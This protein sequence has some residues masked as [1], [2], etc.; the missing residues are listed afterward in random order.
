MGGVGAVASSD[1]RALSRRVDLAIP[2]AL[3]VAAGV[4]WWWSAR[5]ADDMTSMGSGGMG[6]S[7]SMSDSMSMSSYVVGW[8]AMMA[9]MMFP[10][11]APMVKLYARASARG[12]VAPVPFFVAGYLV[13][14]SA[15][16]VPAFFV[17]RA[18]ADPLAEGALWT[19]R[20]AGATFVAAALYQFTPLKSVCLR[21]CRSP[22]SFFLH[23]GSG[24]T[25]TAPRALRLGAAHGGFCLGCCWAIMAVLVAV[26]TMHLGWMLALT[27]VIFA[28]KVAPWGEKLALVAAAG[29]AVF[30]VGLLLDPSAVTTIT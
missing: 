13:V 28:E 16:G 3:F 2:V 21:H 20:L 19:G 15:I 8:V 23:H 24:R 9:A 14:W 6:M 10:A 7:M 30:G 27:V 12:N 22:I 4:G 18:L 17:W 1:V 25:D 29:F 11:I 5:M 26:G